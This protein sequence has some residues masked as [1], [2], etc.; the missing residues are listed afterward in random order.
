MELIFKIF[1][2]IIACAVTGSLIGY[3]YT[4]D[5]FPIVGVW[6]HKPYVCLTTKINLHEPFKALNDWELKL[7]QYKIAS[8]YGATQPSRS[9]GAGRSFL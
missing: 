7:R 2:I 6:D 1:L 8:N 5:Y 9:S 4:D 3:A